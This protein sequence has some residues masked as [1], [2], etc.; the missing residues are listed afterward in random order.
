PL[1]DS[2]RIQGS[3]WSLSPAFPSDC[4]D[5]FC[6]GG[7][8]GDGRLA[9]WTIQSSLNVLETD[10]YFQQ[11]DLSGR[12]N[13]P[14]VL[15]AKAV[16]AND[17]GSSAYF[18][19]ADFSSELHGQTRYAIYVKS[20]NR[21]LQGSTDTM[22]LCKIN[23]RTGEVLGDAIFLRYGATYARI[24]PMGRFVVYMS[25]SSNFSRLLYQALDSTGH[26]SGAPKV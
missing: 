9:Y 15:A 26:T 20:Y 13:M 19:S 11:L 22:F 6:T 10:L 8:S 18:V 2:G 17:F 21:N 5:T 24:D 4:S 12:P 23:S 25:A 14:P 16:A 1:D 7:V 3:G